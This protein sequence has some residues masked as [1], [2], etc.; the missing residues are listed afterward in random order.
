MFDI[1]LP[2]ITEIPS[3]DSQKADN[4]FIHF[5]RIHLAAVHS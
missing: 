1:S 5:T 4:A 3:A 2:F